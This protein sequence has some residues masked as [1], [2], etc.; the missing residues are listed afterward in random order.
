MK[1]IIYVISFISLFLFNNT[2]FANNEGSF[3]KINTV[4]GAYNRNINESLL[5]FD[6]LNS[7]NFYKAYSENLPNEIILNDDVSCSI[8]PNPS[9]ENVFVAVDPSYKICQ[10]SLYDSYGRIVLSKENGY[11]SHIVDVSVK[12]LQQG[13]YFMHIFIDKQNK[14]NKSI[15]KKI[16]KL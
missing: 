14:T 9:S 16:I 7:V 12:N 6:H 5:N 8:F 10:V 11:G 3:S 2:S 13:V 1:K 15:V 4:L